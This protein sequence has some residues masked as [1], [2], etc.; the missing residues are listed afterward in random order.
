LEGEIYFKVKVV[1][2][3][4]VRLNLYGSVTPPFPS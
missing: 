2:S 4:G 1:F 3:N